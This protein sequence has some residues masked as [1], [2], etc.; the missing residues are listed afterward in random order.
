MTD[1]TDVGA[2]AERYGKM[3]RLTLPDGWQS[4]NFGA[5]IQPLT[6]APLEHK[7]RFLYT[8]PATH[9]LTQLD[10]TQARVRQIAPPMM[11]EIEHAVIAKVDEKYDH[12]MAI[13]KAV[14][15]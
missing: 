1:F 15:A 4:E 11:Y 7:G 12:V 3:V 5:F 8:G 10:K 9:D 14:E 13:L 6:Y 2:I